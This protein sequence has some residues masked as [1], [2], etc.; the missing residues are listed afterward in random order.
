MSWEGTQL[1]QVIPTDQR[2]IP[3]CVASCV[4]GRG[5][6]VG[7]AALTLEL[8][9]HC[10]VSGEQLGD[11]CIINFP[12]FCVFVSFPHLPFENPKIPKLSL[13]QPMGFFTFM[14]LILSPF[15]VTGRV[16]EHLCGA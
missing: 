16:S 8:S 7:Q 13:S 14:L 15:P 9:E 2:D 12:C 6:K 3:D 5:K 1:G 10:W 4:A 11:F